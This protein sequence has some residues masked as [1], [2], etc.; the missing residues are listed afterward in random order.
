MTPRRARTP[1]NEPGCPRFSTG[2]GTCDEHRRKHERER[3]ARRR[4]EGDP[5]LYTRARWRK[6]RN[7]KLRSKPLC[8]RCEADGRT[9]PAVDV[10]HKI[11][12][13]HGGDPFPPLDGLESLCKPCHG[14]HT[15]KEQAR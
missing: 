14:R 2:R 10:H 13:T 4:A 7:A 3:S 12:V 15:R 11:P 6:L 8:E 5:G 1:C 9:E